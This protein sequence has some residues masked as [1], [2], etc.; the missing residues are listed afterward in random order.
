MENAK[1]RLAQAV[2]EADT[3]GDVNQRL[4]LDYERSG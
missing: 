1:E 4:H 2:K 3:T